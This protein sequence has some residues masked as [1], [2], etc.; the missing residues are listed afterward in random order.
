M[1]VLMQ[2][3]Q[4]DLTQA[5]LLMSIIAIIGLMLALPT[6]IILQRLGPKVTLLIAL[7][8]T[9]IG[10]GIGA[11]SE[12]FTGLLTSRVPRK[13]CRNLSGQGW[14]WRWCL[15]VRILDSFWDQFSWRDRITNSKAG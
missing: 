11:L 2:T 8:L 12:N 5:G 13:S 14:D 6:G 15:R 1:P 9:A 7:G 10:A 4:I 3:F